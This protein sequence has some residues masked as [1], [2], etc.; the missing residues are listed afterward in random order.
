MASEETGTLS[1]WRRR[2][3]YKSRDPLFLWGMLL[4]LLALG[5]AGGAVTERLAGRAH[6]SRDDTPLRFPFG[7][8]DF[9]AGSA[10]A[11]TAIDAVRTVLRAQPLDATAAINELVAWGRELDEDGRREAGALVEAVEGVATREVLRETL[12]SILGDGRPTEPLLALAESEPGVPHASYAAGLLLD[13]ADEREAAFTAFKREAELEGGSSWAARAKVVE[14]ARRL[15]RLDELNALAADP[16]YA[17]HFD[18]RARL[19]AA[20]LARD[21]LRVPPLI[22]RTQF[23]GASLGRVLFAS[24]AALGWFA[25]CVQF[26]Q[27]RSLLSSRVA[28]CVIAFGLGVFSTT[29]TVFVILWQEEVWGFTER[30]DMI[31]GLVYFI[32][33]VGLREEVVKLLFFLPLVPIVVKRRSELEALM[34]ASCVGLGFAAEEN[35]AYYASSTAAVPRF[36]TANFLHIALTGLAGWSLCSALWYPRHNAGVFVQTF[37]G[38]VVLHGLYDAVIVVPEFAEMQLLFLLCFA[39]IAYW[40]FREL[41]AIRETRRETLSPIATFVFTLGLLVATTLVIVSAYGGLRGAIAAVIPTSL[42][43]AILAYIFL[44]EMPGSMVR[45]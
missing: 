19:E 20:V 45:V 33:G 3:F 34:V 5:L 44:R 29:A 26:A 36:I 18:S 10:N 31:G 14:L 21:W 6:V 22:L 40:Y 13:A 23:E 1:G 28:L 24:I 25:L 39:A 17:E 9:L 11:E 15:E 8:G 42:E 27:P 38:V 2:V 37:V 30:S 16:R 12:E 7:I 32:L 35:L 43:L 41:R 4:V